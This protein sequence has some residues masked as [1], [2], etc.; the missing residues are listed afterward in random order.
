MGLSKEKTI[1]VEVDDKKIKI[2]VKRPTGSISTKAGRIA[3]K[4]WT[5][6]IEDGI[7]TKKEL[8][9]FME[10]RGIWSKEKGKEEENLQQEIADL[11]KELALGNGKTAKIRASQGK[12]LAIKIRQKR[13]DL[14]DLISERLGLEGNTAE[15]LSDNARFDF[16]VACCTYHEN[17][18]KVYKT[19]EEYEERSDDDIA[20]AA[21]SA[22]AEMM[23]SLDNDFEKSLPENKF[24][25]K[26]HYTNEDGALINEEGKTVDLK[27]RLINSDGYYINDNGDRVD[28]EGNLLDEDGRYITTA[29]YVDEE[30]K[31]D[32]TKTRTKTKTKMD[33]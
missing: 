9:A 12:D 22:M 21:A 14:R 30:S 10:K 24:L 28:I 18:E 15:A 3:A 7:M 20:F 5:E 31:V 13:L 29:N 1:D 23:Y 11:E 6:C 8:K 16:L 33:G 32:T 17:G 19:L 26:H 25:S 27:G 2:V 4:V